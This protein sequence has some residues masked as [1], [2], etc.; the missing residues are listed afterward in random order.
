M[1]SELVNT[2]KN[3]EKHYFTKEDFATY[4]LLGSFLLCCFVFKLLPILIAGIA[5]YAISRAIYKL[6]APKINGDASKI[7]ITIV[8]TF[9]MLL[10]CALG[11]GGYYMVRA[12]QA[13]SSINSLEQDIY[14]VLMQLKDY[15]PAWLSNVIPDNFFELKEQMV[16][17]AKESSGKILIVTTTSA[18]LALYILIGVILGSMVSFSVLQREAN[19]M[20]NPLLYAEIV[21][22]FSKSLLTRISLFSDV[23]CKVVVAQVQISTV[24]TILTSIYLFVALPLF[25]V[26][27][28]YATTIVLL[29]FLLG[30]IPILGNLIVNLIVVIISLTVGFKLAIASL[31]FLIVIHKLEYYINAKVVGGKLKIYVW[32]MLIAMV[33][34]EAIFGPIGVVIAP[35]IYGYIK[36]ELKLKGVI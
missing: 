18:K 2:T 36:E 29:T 35:V 31:I 24:N 22:P 14:N 8:V 12:G 34:L 33:L 30:L 10:L 16:A 27:M 13:A 25:G 11:G 9:S 4:I 23:F 17:L 6:I 1:G 20:R 26:K 32:E 21:K 3:T 5:T 7:T 19:K 15:L 28:P